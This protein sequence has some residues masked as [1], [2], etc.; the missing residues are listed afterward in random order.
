M[1][2]QEP[3]GFRLLLLGLA[4][5]MPA[6]WLDTS[7]TGSDEYNIAFR[8][9]LETS[10]SDDWTVP[11]LAGAPR[12]QKPPLY[13]WVL[14]SSAHWFGSS[15]FSMR[16]WGVL[17]GALLAIV[18][19]TLGKRCCGANPTLTFLILISTVGLATESRRAMLDVPMAFLTICSMERLYRW[20]TSG[21][22]GT[23]V[24]AGLLLAIATLIKPTALLF[25]FA[26]ALSLF[27][28][29][30][31]RVPAARL[32]ELAV[33]IFTL[34]VVATPWW[35]LVAD[36]YPQ[37]FEQIWQEQVA[38]REISWLHVEAIPSLLGGLLGLI[39]PWSIVAIAA[40]FTFL[41][42]KSTG[43]ETPER[44]LVIWVILSA[45]PFL[46]MKT[47]ERYLIPVLPVL[48]ILVSSH[49]EALD[50]RARRRHLLIATL[51]IGIPC[52]LISGFVGWF[53][54]SL[55]AA[56]IIVGAWLVMLLVSFDGSPTSSALAG[57]VLLAV[58]M[59]IALPAVGIGAIP[60]FPP[61]CQ[62]SPRAIIGGQFLGTL[63]LRE[64][65]WIPTLATDPQTLAASLPKDKT[66]LIL[67]DDAFGA[68]EEA[69]IIAGRDARKVATF[70]TLRSRK[71]FVRF[72]RHDVTAE[73]WQD[74]FRKRSLA[75]LLIPCSIFVLEESP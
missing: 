53:S 13:Y 21:G 58:V 41:K 63:P 55:I 2:G 44:W 69:L 14:S 66:T 73:D 8:T 4:V 16:I 40:L 72:S 26:G 1:I 20:K 38:R 52:L 6:I 47:F 33:G 51:L 56:A 10:A 32:R 50:E 45:I 49:L 60:R 11:T 37:L 48:A 3:G 17:A 35:F 22:T 43:L 68:L 31:Q 15:P 24:M 57:A 59:G 18:T 70:G 19:A 36:R 75:P 28:A 71:T 39:L 5:L 62:D 42:K 29:G 23:A 9:A 74:A 67:K 7:L 27:I 65:Q 64:G 34:L 54:C 25:G 30:P 61:A 12:L 46:F